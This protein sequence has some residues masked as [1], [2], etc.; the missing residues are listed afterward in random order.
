MS[1]ASF[2][3]I[4]VKTAKAYAPRG[5]PRS[6]A[7]EGQAARGSL[8]GVTPERPPAYHPA[9]QFRRNRRFWLRKIVVAKGREPR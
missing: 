3:R 2:Y 4:P 9:P 5:R 6:S 1:K 7:T 8:L